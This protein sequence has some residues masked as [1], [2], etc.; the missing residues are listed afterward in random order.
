MQSDT[1]ILDRV[2]EIEELLHSLKSRVHDQHD[3]EFIRQIKSLEAALEALRRQ[4]E[5]LGGGE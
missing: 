2:E 4:H 5:A 1:P 3:P